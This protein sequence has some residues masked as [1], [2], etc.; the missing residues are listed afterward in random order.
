[1]KSSGDTKNIPGLRLSYNAKT[2]VF[3]GSF[4]FY[5]YM[6]KKYAAKVTG[7]VVDGVGQGVV[8]CPKLSADSWCVMV[9]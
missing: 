7:L 5:G 1:M 8:T 2:G 9:E 6:G 3:K 4:S